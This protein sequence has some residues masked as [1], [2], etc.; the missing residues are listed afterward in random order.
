M[1]E[2]TLPQLVNL[3]GLERFQ[4]RS[5]ELRA[6]SALT[7]AGLPEALQSLRSLLKSRSHCVST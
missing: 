3:L 2:T 4:D 6:C 1:E 5:W 7:G